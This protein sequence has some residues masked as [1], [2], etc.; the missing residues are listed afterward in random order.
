MVRSAL[1]KWFSISDNEVA[2]SCELRKSYTRILILVGLVFLWMS[3][4][5]ISLFIIFLLN[6]GIFNTKCTKIFFTVLKIFLRVTK[7]LTLR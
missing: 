3:L 4:F 6:R 2:T 1:S 5:S 7:A